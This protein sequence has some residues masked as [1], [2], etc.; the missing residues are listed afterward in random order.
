MLGERDERTYLQR[1]ASG[2][3]VKRHLR[4]PVKR[5][6]VVGVQRLH[7][8]VVLDGGRL[9]FDGGQPADCFA[10]G[11]GGGGHGRG[12]LIKGVDLFLGLEQA[13]LE[14]RLVQQH[15]FIKGGALQG[16]LKHAHLILQVDPIV[17]RP[18]HRRGRALLHRQGVVDQGRRGR[19]GGGGAARGCCQHP[20]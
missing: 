9:G 8:G 12:L 20:L 11:G 7:R 19:R 13:G 6:G 17:G 15:L 18:G 3:H 2:V 16:A 4:Q 14:H 5:R 10:G 1:P